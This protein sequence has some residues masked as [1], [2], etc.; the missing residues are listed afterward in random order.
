MV[1]RSVFVGLTS[2][3]GIELTDCARCSF[4]RTVQCIVSAARLIDV[5]S[6]TMS[7]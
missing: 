2:E 3:V 5:Y 1:T 7:E 6:D 4:M